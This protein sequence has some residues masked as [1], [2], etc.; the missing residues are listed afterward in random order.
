MIIPYLLLLIYYYF[1]N[2]GVENYIK[3]KSLVEYLVIKNVCLIK[4]YNL[5]TLLLIILIKS[6]I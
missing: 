2:L 3:E 5:E 6:D 1:E 4:A